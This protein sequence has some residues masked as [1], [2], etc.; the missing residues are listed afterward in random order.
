MANHQVAHQLPRLFLCCSGSK[1]IGRALQ[2]LTRV[3]YQPCDGG[4]GHLLSSQPA[5]TC[6]A[7]II[8]A[9]QS[10]EATQMLWH[11]HW[12]KRGDGLSA[13]GLAKTIDVRRCLPVRWDRR[14]TVPSVDLSCIDVPKQYMD[15]SMSCGWAD[16]CLCLNIHLNRNLSPARGINVAALVTNQ[17]VVAHFVLDAYVKVIIWSEEG[18]SA[19]NSRNTIDGKQL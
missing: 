12:P 11:C 8:L 17:G 2:A 18:C 6:P 10:C 14:L 9:N 5:A 19:N 4:A 13:E 1:G 7:F 16:V 15:F 3:L